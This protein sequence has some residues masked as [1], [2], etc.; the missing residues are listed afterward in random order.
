MPFL[1]PQRTAPPRRASPAIA[2]GRPLPLC[3]LAKAA[4]VNYNGWD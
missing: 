2:Q 1:A 3:A 4:A